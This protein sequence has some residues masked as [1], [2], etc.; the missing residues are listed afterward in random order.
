MRVDGKKVRDPSAP[1]IVEDFK[2]HLKANDLSPEVGQR[3]Y[4]T[5]IVETKQADARVL[6]RR[7]IPEQNVLNC[8][9]GESSFFS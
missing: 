1:Y 7:P 9:V 3:I 6:L 2:S 5:L 4:D 8:S